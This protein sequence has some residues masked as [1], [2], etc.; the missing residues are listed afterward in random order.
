MYLF[1]SFNPDPTR[2]ITFWTISF[3]TIFSALATFGVGQPTVQRYCALP[4]L[5]QAK[6]YVTLFICISIQVLACRLFWLL[7]LINILYV[8]LYAS[9][10]VTGTC[11]CTFRYSFRCL[12]LIYFIFLLY[13]S[14]IKGSL[15]N[16][17][18]SD[19]AIYNA[20]FEW[21]HCW[22]MVKYSKRY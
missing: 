10:S 11:C 20:K 16:N 21:R 4:T 2:R 17:T 5:R 22:S 12:Y 3:G 6:L 1:F 9:L 14:Y 8:I 18:I 19:C 13:I 7:I 15:K